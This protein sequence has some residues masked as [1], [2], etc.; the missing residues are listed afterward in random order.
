[1]IGER[2]VMANVHARAR[3]SGLSSLALLHNSALGA[4][5]PASVHPSVHALF[6][7]PAFHISSLYC[8]A[9]PHCTRTLGLPSAFLIPFE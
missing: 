1:M 6:I 8:I 9:S 3:S 5:K 7:S 2:R 4:P